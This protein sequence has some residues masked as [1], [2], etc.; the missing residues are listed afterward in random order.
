ME[1]NRLVESCPFV[2]Y[3]RGDESEAQKRRSANYYLGYQGR[4][5]QSQGR[6]RII[7]TSTHLLQSG[8]ILCAKYDSIPYSSAANTHV[9]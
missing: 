2:K 6:R 8:T 3:L 9:C 5:G 7:D 1:E 4:R